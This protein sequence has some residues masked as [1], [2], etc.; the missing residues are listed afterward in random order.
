MTPGQS[1]VLSTIALEPSLL[2]VQ[3]R[4]ARV[5]PGP[6]KVTFSF[7]T[8]LVPKEPAVANAWRGRLPAV[9]V[10]LLVPAEV[11]H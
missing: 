10:S 1:V 6:L 8:S 5:W 11:Q 7:D 3:G 2:R 4:T 9:E